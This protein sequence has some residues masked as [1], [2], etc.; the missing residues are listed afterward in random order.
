MPKFQLPVQGTP[1]IYKLIP[2]FSFYICTFPFRK[3]LDRRWLLSTSVT[4][5][6]CSSTPNKFISSITQSLHFFL[7]LP[8]GHH[9]Q[10]SP[11]LPHPTHPPLSFSHV[12]TISVFSATTHRK[13]FT[14]LCHLTTRP[15]VLINLY[16]WWAILKRYVLSNFLNLLIDGS[17]LMFR[18]RVFHKEGAATSKALS[19]DFRLVT[20]FTVSRRRPS[21]F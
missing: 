3:G 19:P 14:H 20:T 9:P 18:G 1:S 17:S 16:Y 7:G 15:P 5:V 4:C 2:P 21:L 6:T 8:A 12:Q 11:P 10:L 13:V